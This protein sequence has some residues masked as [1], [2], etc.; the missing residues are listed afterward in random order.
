MLNPMAPPWNGQRRVS[1]FFNHLW[2][3]HDI[4]MLCLPVGAGAVTLTLV[5]LDVALPQQC[6]SLSQ[7]TKISDMS[8][9]HPTVQRPSGRG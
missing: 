3:Q 1:L 6:E 7:P 5:N 2:C 9:I 8:E 4:Q